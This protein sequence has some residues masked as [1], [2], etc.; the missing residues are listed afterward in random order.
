MNCW[1]RILVDWGLLALSFKWLTHLW[2]FS[3]S[4]YDFLVLQLWSP[5]G[6]M[7]D[8]TRLADK[9]TVLKTHWKEQ[10]RKFWWEDIK[11]L[12]IRKWIVIMGSTLNYFKIVHR[13]PYSLGWNVQLLWWNEVYDTWPIKA[14]LFIEL[15]IRGMFSYIPCFTCKHFYSHLATEYT[16]VRMPWY[17]RLTA[18]QLRNWY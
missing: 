3:M 5:L 14:L 10:S 15:N 11:N 18:R 6:L 2:M 8:E 9:I 12:V 17:D 1:L 13:S 16:W 7:T 4:A